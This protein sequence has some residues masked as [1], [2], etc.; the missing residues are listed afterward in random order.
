MSVVIETGRLRLRSHRDDDL[1]NLIAL[2]SNWEV[3]RWLIT[4][5][6]PYSAADGQR[7]GL[8]AYGNE[9]GHPGAFTVASK[10]SDQ[11]I[12]VVGIDGVSIWQRRG[13]AATRLKVTIAESA[14]WSGVAVARPA[15]AILSRLQRWLMQDGGRA[16]FGDVR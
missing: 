4:L 2:A 11:L 12:G 7:N 6:H 13:T 3:A 8:H 14:E 1:R 5:A 10:E 15:L 16:Q 9:A